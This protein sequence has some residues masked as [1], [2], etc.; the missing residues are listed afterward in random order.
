MPFSIYNAP[1]SWQT[2]INKVL[3]P[4]L[5]DTCIAFLD[6]ILI[7][8]DSDKEI[9]VRTFKVLDYLREEGLY[10]KLSKCRFKVNEVDFLEYLVSHN[11]LHIDS[12]RVQAI[13]D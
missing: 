1:A 6:D 3:G 10:Y 5:N 12:D 2:Y 4:L 8:G 9:R 7:W 11:E 13:K